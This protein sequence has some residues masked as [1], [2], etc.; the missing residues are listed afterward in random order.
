MPFEVIT[1]RQNARIVLAASLKNK[2]H[3]DQT[4]LFCAEGRMLLSEAILSGIYP[5]TVFATE[6]NLPFIPEI[7]HKDTCIVTDE[8]FK[9]ISN[10]DCP[11]G[12]M[13]IFEKF[14]LPA[15]EPSTAIVLENLQDP[16]N[17]GTVIRTAAALGCELCVCASCA[18]V[19]NPKTQRSAMG[20]LFRMPVEIC[21]DSEKA[22]LSLKER[23]FRVVGA[24]LDKKS[25][26]VSETDLS[27]KCA[28]VIGNE[29]HGLTEKA[30]ELCD[31]LSIIPMKGMES[32]NASVAAS[33]YIWEM[34]KTREK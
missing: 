6:E 8:V 24:A 25:L 1:S 14:T 28:V 19:F 9:K 5:K 13:S 12:V 15:D 20:A 17:V 23:G 4:G 30:K 3:R 11:E 21:S 27:G 18:D 10:D 31:N 16:G 2:K 34:L 22:I 7:C 32:L 33:L 29:G 26:P